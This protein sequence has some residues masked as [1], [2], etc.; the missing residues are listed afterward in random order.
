MNGLQKPPVRLRWE[1]C[2]GRADRHPQLPSERGCPSGKQQRLGRPLRGGSGLLPRPGG[3]SVSP[4]VFVPLLVGL[5]RGSHCL[6]LTLAQP[7]L[8]QPPTNLACKEIQKYLVYSCARRQ[9]S[10][11][12]TVR[13]TH[14]PPSFSP[15]FSFAIF[16][17]IQ[18]EVLLHLI[19]QHISS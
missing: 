1:N 14:A 19:Q 9:V 13:L 11:E 12:P 4:T 3:D 8:D 7:S 6:N 17:G 10:P 5:W 18:S 16:S 15:F 2:K